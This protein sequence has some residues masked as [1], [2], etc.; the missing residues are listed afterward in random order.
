LESVLHE[1]L[2]QTVGAKITH[3]WGGVLGV[4]RDWMPS[5]SFDRASGLGW[6]GGYVGDGV[7]CAALAGRTLADLVLGRDTDRSKLPWVNHA[8]KRWEPEPFRWIGIRGMNA[9][10]ASADVQESKTGRPARR[11]QLLDRLTG[12]H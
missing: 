5:V 11:A 8:W 10:M 1:L 6:A 4:P 7:A 12:S 2:P 9:L 3:R